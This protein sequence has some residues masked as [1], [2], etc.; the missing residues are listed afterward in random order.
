LP[1]KFPKKSIYWKITGQRYA[2]E[3]EPPVVGTRDREKPALLPYAARRRPDF[4]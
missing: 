3:N 1:H 2:G 4:A